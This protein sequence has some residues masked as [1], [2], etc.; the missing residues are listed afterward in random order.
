MPN[1]VPIL[2]KGN[3]VSETKRT[4]PAGTPPTI[5]TPGYSGPERRSEFRLWR[6]AVD[7][8]LDAGNHTMKGLRIDLDVQ[9]VSIDAMKL[10]LAANT[11]ATNGVKA[12][13][14]ELVELLRSFKGAFKVLDM[15]AKLAR[16]LG[17][18]A[19]AV[20]AFAGLFSAF[21]GGGHVK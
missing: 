19:M 11:A 6:E 17:V 20:V 2:K 21:K 1:R 15:I 12:D 14:S 4:S 9:T 13:T 3:F 8:R 5:V 10:D 7:A 16:P 18:L